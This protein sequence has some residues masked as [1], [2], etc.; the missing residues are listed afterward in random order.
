LENQFSSPEKNQQ[1]AKEAEKI[2]QMKELMKKGNVQ[3]PT[4][5]NTVAKK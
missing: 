1:A 4:R 3:V 2:A 5:S